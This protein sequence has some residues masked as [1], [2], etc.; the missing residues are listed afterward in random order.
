M[1]ENLNRHAGRRTTFSEGLVGGPAW[2][3]LLVARRLARAPRVWQEAAAGSALFNAA[4]AQGRSIP[5]VETSILL[6]RH[7]KPFT[8]RPEAPH[9]EI[10][11]W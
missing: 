7:F 2:G 5:W 4:A 10:S 1:T 11:P 3:L 8:L 9:R 6:R